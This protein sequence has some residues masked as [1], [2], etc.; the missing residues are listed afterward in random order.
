VWV[1]LVDDGVCGLFI[2]EKMKVRSVVQFPPVS[3]SVLNK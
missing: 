2:A 3:S 1:D